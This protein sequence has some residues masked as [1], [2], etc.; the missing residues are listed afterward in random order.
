MLGFITW[1]VD[2]AIISEPLEVRWYGLMFAMAFLLGYQVLK[3]IFVKEGVSEDW[4]DKILIY[5]M[6]GTVI[7]ARLGHVFFYD[8]DYYSENLVDILNLRQGGLASH[9]AAIGIVLSL[10]L[11]SVRVSKKP[12]LWAFDR[13]ALV[14]A[15]GAFFIRIGNFFNH[16]I[17][18]IPTEMPWGVIFTQAYVVNPELPRHPA[19]LYEAICYILLF[20]WLWRR[21]NTTEVSQKT[22][23][24]FGWFLVVM[25]IAR[26][27]VEFVKNSQGGFESALGVLS[28]G[29]WLSIPFVLIGAYFIWASSKKS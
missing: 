21:W 6:V 26:F 2:P 12:I 17:I 19:Q 15:L 13:V 23:N 9:G 16:E 25:F 20:L 28:T 27:L 5:V 3:K 29:Q 22:G 1:T 8:W 4:L 24:T 14:V 7:G 11:F 10:W 18:G